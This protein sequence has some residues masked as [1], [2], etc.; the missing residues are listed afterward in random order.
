MGAFYGQQSLISRESWTKMLVDGIDIS[1][2]AGYSGLASINASLINDKNIT[3][4][5]QKLTTQQ[6]IY[7]RGAVP[8]KDGNPLSWSD[9]T[10]NEPSMLSISL[11]PI[12]SLPIDQYVKKS[13][14]VNLKKA[15][16]QY[17]LSLKGEGEISSCTGPTPDPP[18]PKPRTKSRWSNHNGGDDFPLQVRI[19]YHIQITSL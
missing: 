2:T 9:Q 6:N 11:Q 16:K 15:F 4:T 7:T 8:P 19:N 13:V 12:Y 5:F 14:K 1:I 17:C 3:K 18:V 10:K